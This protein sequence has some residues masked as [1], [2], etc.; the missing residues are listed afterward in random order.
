MASAQISGEAELAESPAAVESS[1]ILSPTL[2]QKVGEEVA[3]AEEGVHETTEIHPPKHK[4]HAFKR[5]KQLAKLKGH[6]ES[7][8]AHPLSDSSPVETSTSPSSEKSSDAPAESPEDG[9]GNDDDDDPSTLAHKIRELISTLPAVIHPD[10]PEPAPAPSPP[11]QDASGC[12]IPPSSAVHIPRSA[13]YQPSF[14]PE[15]HER[16][17]GG[18]ADCVEHLADLLH[19]PLASRKGTRPLAAMETRALYPPPSPGTVM[20]YVPLEPT[21]G[22]KV[23]VAEFAL[24]PVD[25]ES[26]HNPSTVMLATG[27][28]WWP[29]HGKKGQT[30][31]PPTS[32]PASPSVPK[33]TPAKVKKVWLPSTTKI[34]VEATWWGYRIFLP[35]PVMTVLSN[36]E[37]EAVKRATMIST[38]LTWLFAIFL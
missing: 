26:N 5:F 10:T 17:E 14:Q 25:S 9:N 20:L 11:D 3:V 35:P 29:F 31:E 8:V 22:D 16:K 19:L 37:V 2:E 1:D 4:F 27:W 33:T 7:Q 21:D 36:Q 6:K 34:S 32:A 12:P 13:P 23:E 30:A 24:V 15:C 18:M 38:A 28:K